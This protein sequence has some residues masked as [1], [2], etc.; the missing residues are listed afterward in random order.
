MDLVKLVVFVPEAGSERLR[1]ALGEA[2]AG[3]IGKYSFCSWSVSGTG[4]FRPEEGA[5]PH[6]GTAGELE[7]VAE[8]R[9]EVTCRRELAREIAQVVRSVHPY[10]EVV[11]DL[12][13]MLDPDDL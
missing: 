4:R 2:G 8:E 5:V 9:I 10:E 13:P 11:I 7:T 1:K 6:I 12:Y 3:Y